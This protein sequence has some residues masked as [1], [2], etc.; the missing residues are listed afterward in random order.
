MNI[1]VVGDPVLRAVAAVVK[2]V[3][4]ASKNTGTPLLKTLHDFRKENGFGRG[5]A[6][7]QIGHSIRMIAVCLPMYRDVTLVINPEVSWMS[8]EMFALWDD[9]FSFPDLMVA[10][11][12]H[13]S[14]SVKFVDQNGEHREW[15]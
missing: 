2:D 3:T 12:R 15:R 10:V 5:I 7:P 11:K 13:S 4:F 1:R 14:L 9:C 6:A 8:E